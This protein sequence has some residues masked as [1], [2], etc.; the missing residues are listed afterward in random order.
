M[1][2]GLDSGFFQNAKVYISYHYFEEIRVL[3]WQLYI[4][5]QRAHTSYNYGSCLRPGYKPGGRENPTTEASMS[6]D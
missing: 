3:T 6:S 4:L 5:T 2:M 1:Y